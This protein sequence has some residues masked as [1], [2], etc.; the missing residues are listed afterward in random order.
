MTREPA[1]T[2]GALARLGFSSTD[3]ARRFLAE[4][5]LAGLG[6]RAVA[7]LGRTA[8]G[9]DA[10]LGLLR[11]AESAQEAG[12]GRLCAEFLG[13]IGQEGSGGQRLITLLGSSVALGDVLARHPELLELLREGDDDLALEAQAVRS[14]LLEAVGADPAAEVPVAADGGREV[15]DA[16]RVAYHGRLAQIAAA[17]V[18]AEDPTA[19]QPQVS[20]AISDLAD[21]ALEAA[22][23][24]ARATVE[25]HEAV[26]WAVIALGKT[27]ARE[28][29][30]ISDVDVMH[31]VAPAAHL[32]DEDGELAAEHEEH[33]LRVG[34]ALAR[35]LARA[36]SE[37]T[38]EG[39]LWQVDANLRPEG[40]DGPLVRT[41]ASYRRYYTEWAKSWE[42]QALLKARAAA[43]DRELGAEYEE[44]VEPWV[45]KAS[46][47]EGFVEDARAMRRRVVAHI[48]RAEV[49]RNLKLGPGGLR[50]V[51]FTVQLLQMVH[52]RTDEALQGRSTLEAL[53]RLGEGGYIS[54]T[55]VAEMDEAY[56]FL[57]CVEHRLQLHRLR[58]TQVLPTAASDLRRLARS[59][60]EGTDGFHQRYQRT[61]RRVRQLHEEIF[62]RPLLLTASQLSDGEIRLSRESAA[63]RLEAIGYRDPER[64][65]GHITA[66]TEGISRRAKIQ[67]HLLP[68]MLEWFADGVD[69][70]LG[71]LGF[72][73][74][75]D[76]IG[77]AHWYLGLLRDSG[78]AA[79][80]LT[81]VLAAGRYVGEQLEQIPEAV[82]WLARDEQLRPLARDV[83]GREF[84]AVISRV[85]TIEVAQDVLR[86]TRNRELLRIA[87]AHLTGVAT[88][89][90]VARALT[91]LAEAVLEAGMLVA[92][93]VV[94]R[95]RKAI[96]EDGE[97][98]DSAPEVDVETALRLRERRS[99]PAR[100]LGIEMAILALG[101]FGAREMG[102]S[103]DA[104]V[105]FV[106]LDRGA[107][108]QTVEIAI[109]VATRTQH[110]LNAPTARADMRV[111]ADLRPEGRVGPLARSLDSWS[112]YYRRDAETWEKQALLRARPVVASEAV[113][114]R[115]R[116]EMDRH[117]YPA[118][119][120]DA[121][122]RR[123]ITRMK[124]RVESERLP[125][126]ADPS[127]HVKLGRGGMTDVEWCMQ[128]LALEHG[129][130]VEALRTE[131][132]L[133]LLEAAGEVEL[134]PVRD[135]RELAEAWSLAWLV[136][137]SLFLWKGRE[138]DVL[139]TDRHDLRALALLIDGDDGSASELE[140][141]YLR[142][143]RRARS[144]AEEIIFGPAEM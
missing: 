130:E 135:V 7:A 47:R 74:L 56:R 84:L 97:T 116:E 88:A 127:R 122:A 23:A 24:I 66:L 77:S 14:R 85:D 21:A 123:E 69:P 15:R 48:P 93:H 76:T 128:L 59:L 33:V 103:S 35:E 86:R 73:R 53:A 110:I 3:R 105:Q 129:H 13:S 63:A 139:P 50:D 111:S 120:I 22:S 20:A 19:L 26:R 41:L 142:L 143:T 79:K 108:A 83:L 54:R 32:C 126:N 17:D 90:E 104:D 71:L 118:G 60:G 61:R 37:R 91:D 95:E 55:H 39:S 98:L 6:D 87:L 70:D 8:D 78:L 51:E 140:E 42:F 67:R 65:L 28:L 136:R 62:Y 1:T 45:W 5:V 31:V 125:R 16:L 38:G 18:G 100:A 68:A 75:S 4:P 29:N 11:L 52:G 117:R 49:E 138:G 80:R 82:R 57:R 99:D 94:A 107:G 101:S 113:A 34:A 30:Y 72:R 124:A 109:A 106:V 96:G 9:D 2:T 121:S 112:D 40:K 89:E 27:G 44:M 144:I 92:L 25:G 43:G 114:A 10:V 141:R 64:A 137:R 119:G 115:L 36:C 46:T 81:R 134:L 12:Q 102:Y 133:D 131:H 58:R 132:T